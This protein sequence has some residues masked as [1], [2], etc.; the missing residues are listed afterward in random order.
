MAEACAVPAAT[1][2]AY[3][4]GRRTLPGHICVTM[5]LAVVRFLRDALEAAELAED[6]ETTRRTPRLRRAV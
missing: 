1:L 3:E 2:S 6:Q 4:L 5:H